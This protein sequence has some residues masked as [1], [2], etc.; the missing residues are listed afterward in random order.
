MK[1]SDEEWSYDNTTCIMTALHIVGLNI[2]FELNK[3]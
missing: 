2:N 1:K 3:H